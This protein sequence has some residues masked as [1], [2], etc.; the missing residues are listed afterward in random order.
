MDFTIIAILG[1]GAI[2]I[3]LIL[4]IPGH[5]LAKYLL[6]RSSPTSNGRSRITGLGLLVYGTLV[7]ALVAGFAQ[8]HLAPNT[9]YGQFMSTW[10]GQ[11]IYGTVLLVALSFI[12]IMLKARGHILWISASKEDEKPGS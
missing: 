5:L 2:V 8:E 1:I 4:Y 11:F 6:R 9:W 10:F 12:E 7:C 3:G